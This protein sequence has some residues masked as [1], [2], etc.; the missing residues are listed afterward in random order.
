VEL[1]IFDFR[2]ARGFKLILCSG[3]RSFFNISCWGSLF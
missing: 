1:D 3:R 2:K